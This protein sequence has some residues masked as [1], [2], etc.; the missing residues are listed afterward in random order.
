MH[1][2][3]RDPVISCIPTAIQR[4]ARDY[5]HV[6][7]DVR[8]ETAILQVEDTQTVCPSVHRRTRVGRHV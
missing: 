1:V 5:I 8:H 4:N 7:R 3:S 6:P 2:V